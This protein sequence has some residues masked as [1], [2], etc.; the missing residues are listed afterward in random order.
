LERLLPTR[1]FSNSLF[2]KIS[3]FTN[4]RVN[5]DIEKAFA[6]VLDIPVNVEITI[7]GSHINKFAFLI[8]YSNQPYSSYNAASGEE[9]LINILVDIFDTPLNSLILIDEIEAG[10][11]PSIQRKLA[12]IIQ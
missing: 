8:S 11:H 5:L 12:D 7:I 6:Y 3:G 1:N 10:F 2:R 4:S 9:S